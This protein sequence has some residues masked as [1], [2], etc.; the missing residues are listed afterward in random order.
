MPGSAS[1][2]ALRSALNRLD[3][4][5]LVGVINSVGARHDQRAVERLEELAA[6]G[7]PDA[8]VAA[9]S[10]LASIDASRFE[11]FLASTTPA[12]RGHLD[13]A[14]L[15]CAERLA[16]QGQTSLAA[17]MLRTLE[18]S[19]PTDAV[20]AA[21][22]LGIV[23][24][25][26]SSDRANLVKNLLASD[27]DWEFTVG[28][29]AAVQGEAPGGATLLAAAIRPES[30]SRHVRIIRALRV[31]GDHATVGVAR[32]AAGSDLLA[33]RAEGIKAVGAL[34]DASDAP[35]L[36]RLAL[37]E[38][39][40]SEAA[41]H[42]LV[43]IKDHG[44]DEALVA[45][46]KESDANSRALAAEL[47][48]RRRVTAGAGALIDAARLADEPAVRVAALEAAGRLAVGETLPALL[49]LAAN[50]RSVAERT[51][52][53]QA[54]LA[55]ASRLT[56]REQAAGLIA[57]RLLKA[58]YD[59]ASVLLNVLA[60]IGGTRSLEIVAATAQKPDRDLQDQATRVLGAWRTPDAAP[61]LQGLAS[62]NHPFSVRALRGYLRIARQL[63][64]SESE[65][66][67]MCREA[68]GIA[69]R[70]EEKL[71][72]LR[73]LER[74]PSV[75]GLEIASGELTGD[76]L[77]KQASESVV[78]IAEAVAP[79]H[80]AAAATA[81]KLVLKTGGSDDVISR[82]KRLTTE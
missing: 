76:R 51:L 58:P 36:M 27:D 6:A 23:R 19:N 12:S 15:A 73:I 35:L 52:A 47:I 5:L 25:S 49:D 7:D 31:L 21:A 64:A 50:S 59:Q 3:G 17:A 45:M 4:D 14:V 29:Q 71:L 53:E 10:A 44:L 2:E 56:D 11:M 79:S 57:D 1:G 33:V 39:D 42:S 70:D 72:A 67:R 13:D 38:D 69:S 24:H 9:A 78:Q 54:S 46:L 68:L 55:A 62:S 28:L 37:A 32:E 65:R 43:E 41:R 77:G 80:S 26:Q 74:I 75:E 61:V 30:P 22:I 40:A 60:T 20:R 66:L 82:A 8:A 34:G 16:E 63:E 18:E 81:A 48:G